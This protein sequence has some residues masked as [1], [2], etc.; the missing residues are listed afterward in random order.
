MQPVPK[1]PA[2]QRNCYIAPSALSM[3]LM[4]IPENIE[5]CDAKPVDGKAT[6]RKLYELGT[7]CQTSKIKNLERISLDGAAAENCGEGTLPILIGF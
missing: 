7:M 4:S 6:H 1:I 5:L 2:H 3:A